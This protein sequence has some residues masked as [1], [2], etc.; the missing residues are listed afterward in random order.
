MV[1]LSINRVEDALRY[2]KL[3]LKEAEESDNHWVGNLVTLKLALVYHHMGNNKES[4]HYLRRFLRNNSG[5]QANLLLYPYLMELCWA[6]ESGGLPAVPGLSLE[7]EIDR[8]LNIRNIFMQ[9]IAY[10]YKALLGEIQ[11]FGQPGD[12]PAIY[13]F[14]KTAQ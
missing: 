1:M 3:S 14:C 12:H 4:L 6:I 9:G 7:N 13:S 2:L 5:P 10:R 11:R 8:M